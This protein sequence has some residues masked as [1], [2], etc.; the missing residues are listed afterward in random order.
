M[1][2]YY[3][4]ELDA[5]YRVA[6]VD[7]ALVFSARHVPVQKLTATEVD[8]FRAPGGLTFHFERSASGQAPSADRKSVV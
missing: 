5:T 6:V 4:E 3:S 1:G 2:D 8:T 7:G